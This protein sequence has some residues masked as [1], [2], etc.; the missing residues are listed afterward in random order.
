LT[1]EKARES[2][3]TKVNLSESAFRWMLNEDQMATEKL[4]DGIRSFAADA[5]KLEKFV[6]KKLAD[7]T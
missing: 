7:L 3:T 6:A 5:V 2:T 4:S 1:P